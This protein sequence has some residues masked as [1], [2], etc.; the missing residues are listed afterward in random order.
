MRSNSSFHSSLQKRFVKA[1]KVL[2]KL[3]GEK[4]FKKKK[5]GQALLGRPASLSAQPDSAACFPSPLSPAR[6]TR[7]APPGADHVA[8]VRRR[9]GRAAADRLTPVGTAPRAPTCHSVPRSS[10]SSSSPCEQQQRPRRRSAARHWRR[11]PAPNSGH[12]RSIKPTPSSASTS[13]ISCARTRPSA[14]RY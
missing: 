2:F 10:L 6:G 11:S 13:A 12:P 8:A 5:R 7:L 1:S 3:F 4:K 9:R 14:S